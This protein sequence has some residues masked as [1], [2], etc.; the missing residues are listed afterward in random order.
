MTTTALSLSLIRRLLADGS[1]Q[2]V[3]ESAG[4][5]RAD[6]A[7]DLAVDESTIARWEARKRV[8][9]SE[10]ALRYGELLGELLALDDVPEKA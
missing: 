5:S 8:P 1:A 9:R 2:R 3:R 10:V 7:R 6:V 4:L